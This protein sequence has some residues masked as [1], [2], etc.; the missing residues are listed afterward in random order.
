MINS[1]ASAPNSWVVGGLT[2]LY[3]NNE[4]S[5]LTGPIFDFTS[6]STPAISFNV[7]WESEFSWDGVVLQS[8]IDGGLNW[9]NVGMFGDPGNWYTDTTISGLAWTGLQEGWTGRVAT[10]SGGWVTAVHELNGLGGQ[11]S[12][13]LR[14]AFGSDGSVQGEGLAFDDILIDQAF[15]PYPGTPGGDVLLGT[16]VNAAP[17]SGLNQFIKTATAFDV[18]GLLTSSPMGTYDG[19][20]YVLLTQPFVTGTPPTP[21]IPGLVYIDLSSPFVI[22]VDISPFLTQI[23]NPGGT[24]Y[25]F[26]MP[27]GFAGQS[28]LFQAACVTPALSVSDGY[29]IQ[30]Q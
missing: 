7:W 8:S 19:Q 2:G 29:E 18:I 9:V 23:V 30:V 10:G 20:P 13:L 14:F 17:S 22:L 25:T 6:L 5:F 15:V 4:Q 24:P 27:P 26:T 1:A 11:S 3:N 28:F 16:G 12:V 21:T